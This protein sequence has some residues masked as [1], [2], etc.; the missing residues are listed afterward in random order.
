MSRTPAAVEGFTPFPQKPRVQVTA[1][2]REAERTALNRA[3]QPEMTYA[4]AMEAL[5]A[6]TLTRSVLTEKGHVCPN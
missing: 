3:K 4:E 5:A 6:G 2:P 1:E